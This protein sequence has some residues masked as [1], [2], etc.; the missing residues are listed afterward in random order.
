MIW[1]VVACALGLPAG[2][3][4][5]WRVPTCE[6]VGCGSPGD[7]SIVIPARNEERNLYRLLQSV[8]KSEPYPRELIVVDD[9]S[10]DATATVAAHS[11]AR[12]IRSLPLP[13]GWTGKNWACSQGAKATSSR[14]LLFLDADTFFGPHGFHK[15]AGCY[16]TTDGAHRVISVLPYHVME[17]AYEQL[18]LIF[19]L[20][21]AFG[22][23][24]FGTIGKG[25]LFGQSLLISSE[26][27]ERSGGHA[28]VR[29]AIL[30]NVAL[31]GNVDAAGYTSIRL[32]GKGM[33][34]IRMF[35]DGAGQLCE[36]WT[37]AFADGAAASD[38]A[39]LYLSIFWLS[40]MFASVLL[41]IFALGSWKVPFV[42]LYACFV[43]Q[44]A[45]LARRIGNYKFVTCLL[46]PAPLTFFFGIFGRSLY[47]RTFKRKVTWR[48][49]SL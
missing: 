24:G 10:I 17:E 25:R 5:M 35:P 1:L 16:A 4:L 13:A 48:G 40:A 34:N 44:L 19:N 36:S 7:T 23:G 27:Y 37:K 41:G 15:L 3:L 14:W 28:G 33:L 38:P 12:V 42:V 11:G 18:S 43:F 8:W 45:W 49:R 47:R 9:G 39:V 2:I 32:G 29:N 31:S 26:A 22:A 21:M 30:E 6:A 20:L 46:F